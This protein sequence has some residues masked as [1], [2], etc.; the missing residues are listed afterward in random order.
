MDLFGVP[1][2]WLGPTRAPRGPHVGPPTW[3][4][5]GPK[6]GNMGAKSVQ[7]FGPNFLWVKNIFSNL[8]PIFIGGTYFQEFGPV[9]SWVKNMFRNLVPIFG[10][11]ELVG[12]LPQA[13]FSP[14]K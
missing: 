1:N 2:F 7:E 3:A 4:P 13:L 8:V 11:P 12:T 5:R 6:W 14:E 10:S 9:F